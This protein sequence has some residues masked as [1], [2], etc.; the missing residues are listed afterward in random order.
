MRGVSVLTEPGVKG[1]EPRKT[2]PEKCFCD[3]DLGERSSTPS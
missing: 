2:L 1:S 3:N